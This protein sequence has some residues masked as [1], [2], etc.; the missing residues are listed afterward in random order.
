VVPLN[1]QQSVADKDD[2]S[3]G[4]ALLKEDLLGDWPVRGGLESFLK[5]QG[6]HESDR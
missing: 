4:V 5:I 1:F 6:I 2:E 3:G